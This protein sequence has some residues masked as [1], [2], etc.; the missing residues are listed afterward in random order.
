MEFPQFAPL[1]V[2]GGG[3][4]SLR[5]AVD[6]GW[7]PWLAFSGATELGFDS[8]PAKALQLGHHAAFFFFLT[9]LVAAKSQLQHLGS[10]YLTRNITWTPCT[11]GVNS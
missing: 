9:F 5:E 8:H 3:W 6:G 2:T 1:P 4:C 10:S 7:R 11:G